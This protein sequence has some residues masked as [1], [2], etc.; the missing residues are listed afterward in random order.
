[1]TA[2]EKKITIVDYGMGNL[3]S[4][5]NMIR[6]LG[7]YAVISADPEEIAAAEKIILPGVGSFGYAMERIGELG[8]KASLD[9]AALN[10]KVPLLGI[11]LGMQLL[12]S[13]SEEGDC[14][15]LG[16]I[17]AVTTRY[18]K[19]EVGE[20][21]IPH[22]GWDSVQIQNPCPLVEEIS[23]ADRFYFVHSY[24]VA[25]K[26]RKDCIATT[27]Y[28]IDADTI[29]GSGNVLGAQFHPEK[30]HKFGMKLMKNFLEKY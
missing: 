30:S 20:E 19:E 26:D 3:R 28:G 21:K 14:R 23:E 10:R 27:H 22:M 17:D 5:K 2:L 25:C 11:C 7:G 4:V 9:E 15:G 6:Y 13:Y 1:M 16:Y 18:T 8:L 24:H 29:I 12:T